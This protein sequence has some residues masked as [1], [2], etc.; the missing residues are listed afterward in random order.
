MVQDLQQELYRVVKELGAQQQHLL[1][2]VLE[3]VQA[4]QLLD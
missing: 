4:A 2:L 1:V 3:V